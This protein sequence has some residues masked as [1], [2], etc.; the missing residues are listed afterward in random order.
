[1]ITA[2]GHIAI[3]ARDIEAT[4]KF[5]REALGLKEAFRMMTPAGDKVGTIYIY[6]APSQFLE[7]Y[8]GDIGTSTGPA[9]AGEGSPLGF[10]HI[11]LEVDNVARALEEARARGA[12]IDGELKKGYSRCIQFWTHDPDGNRVELMEL[13]PDCLQTEANKRL[14][15]T[16]AGV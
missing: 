4:A 6:I 14:A 16:K 12:P 7:I 11:C 8:S 1:M 5:Y 3:G 13:P 9:N 10:S 15:G 2:L